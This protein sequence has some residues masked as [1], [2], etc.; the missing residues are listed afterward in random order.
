MS[1]SLQERETQ[2]DETPIHRPQRRRR[3]KLEIFKEAYLPYLILLA[4]AILICSFLLGA[5]R[6]E[7]PTQPVAQSSV[8][9]TLVL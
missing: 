6:R 5:I 9:Q 4:A 7:Q 2:M 8:S 3:S 1:P